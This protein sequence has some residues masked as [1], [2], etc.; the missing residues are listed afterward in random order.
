MQLR[1]ELKGCKRIVI[2]V[3]S[4]VVTK[5][6]GKCD[7][8]KMRIIAEDISDL[9]D[10][11]FEVVLVSSGAV[12][13]G[14]AFLKEKLP[15]SGTTDLQQS[16]S[17]IGQPKLIS[18]YSQLFEEQEHICAQI[19]L[20]HDDF[21]NRTRFL[22]AKQAVEILLENKIIPILNENDSVSYNLITVGD[23]DHLAASAAQ[24][25]KADALLIIT[26]AQGLFDKDPSIKDAKLIKEVKYGDDLNHI[27]MK[28]KSSVGRGGMHSKIQAVQKATSLGIKAIISS[29]DSLRIVVDPLTKEIGTFFSPQANFD[30]EMKKAWL[31]STKKLDCVIEV[32]SGAYNALVA[33]HS[34]LP[35]GIINASGNFTRGD[36]V[37]ILH[38]GE[39]FAVGVTEYDQKDILKIKQI[40]S[41]DIEKTL[42]FKNSNVV[43]HTENLAIT[44]ED[45]ND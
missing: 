19:L 18:Q 35:K 8:R 34:L 13:V 24:M 43:I 2:K 23:N 9:V 6:N 21:K 26:G 30:P 12:S 14:K 45:S 31:V 40:H 39:V 5:D 17:S 37:D 7:T 41:D 29:R 32:D 10:H 36:C 16:A 3:G 15:R 4:N 22:N 38:Q 33:G 25:I 11:G 28:N 1:K 42:G 20:T 27:N 44:E